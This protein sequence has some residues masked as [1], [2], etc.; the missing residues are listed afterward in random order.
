M[1]IKS[2]CF[3][4]ISCFLNVLSLLWNYSSRHQIARFKATEGLYPLTALL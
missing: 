4:L 2:H 1:A 3:G